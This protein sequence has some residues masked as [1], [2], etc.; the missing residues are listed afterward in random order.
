[1]DDVLESFR[2]TFEQTPPP[3]SAKKVAGRRAYEHARR[4][5]AI[6]LKPV[7]VTVRELERLPSSDPLLVRLRLVVSSG[8]YVRSLAH[9]IGQRLGCGAHLERLERTRAGRFRLHEACTMEALA[10]GA[11][12]FVSLNQLLEDLPAVTLSDEGLSRVRH[13]NLVAAHHLTGSM[14][15]GAG[16]GRVRLMTPAGELAAVAARQ[17][18]ALL[19][20]QVV[21]V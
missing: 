7:S 15:D 21:L 2:G 4:Q 19:H 9:D 12:P 5:Q 13:G 10:S 3:Y 20:P 1:M 6:E 17:D 18:D 8:F 14:P 11:A 16:T